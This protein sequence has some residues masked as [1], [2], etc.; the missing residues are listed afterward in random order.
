LTCSRNYWTDDYLDLLVDLGKPDTRVA[1]R[2]GAGLAAANGPCRD[3]D[4]GAVVPALWRDSLGTGRLLLGTDFPYENGDTFFKNAVLGIALTAAG[5]AATGA[6][7]NATT[8]T[9]RHATQPATASQKCSVAANEREVRSF[10]QDV[11]DEHHGDHAGRYLTPDM[12][13]YGGTVGTVTG[14]KD[15]TGLFAG[16]VASLPNVQASIE[17]IFGQGDQVVVRVVVSGTQEGA[18]LGIPATGRNIHWDGVDIYRLTDGK[19][20]AIWAG[21]D[22]TAILYYT[23]TY[24]A[25]WI[26]RHIPG[27][28]L[29]PTFRIER[30]RKSVR[31]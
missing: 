23:G 12:Q 7:A 21:D 13:W 18:L 16:V 28:S 24:K 4:A 31:L 11:I 26:H 9:A 15:V 5:L 14:R 8:A 6:T 19:I 27:S 20:S 30:R 25:P 17:D 2:S 1:R 29:M 22:W 3:R 10:L